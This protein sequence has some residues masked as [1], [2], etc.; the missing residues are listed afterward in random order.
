MDPLD[1]ALRATLQ[2]RLDELETAR[3]IQASPK[4]TIKPSPEQSS[5]E[6]TR[7]DPERLPIISLDS[8]LL[9]DQERVAKGSDLELRALLGQGGMG[10]VHSAFQYSLG[11]EV[12][13]KTLRED[14]DVLSAD[15]LLREA[16]L[17]GKLEHPGIVP[18]HALG[19]DENGAP[20]LVMKR[21]EG[22]QW[23]ALIQN[24]DHPGWARRSPDRVLA[25]LEI[26]M[27]ICQTVEFAHKRGVVHRDIKPENVMLGDFGEA[28]L[29]DWGIAVRLDPEGS[30]RSSG[31]AGT[32]AYM[33]PEMVSGER[34]DERSDVYL[35]GATLHEAL[36]GELRNRGETMEAVLVS[37]MRP[38]SCIYDTRVPAEIAAIMNRATSRDP[39]DRFP[40][41]M[42][43]REA[44]AEHL[45]H[46]GSVKLADQAFGRCAAL[47]TLMAESGDGKAPEDLQT[48]YQIASETR[49]AFT[50]ALREWPGNRDARTGLL[51]CLSLTVELE[52][53]QGH[54]ET[55]EALLSDIETPSTELL[56][57]LE[58]ARS[59]RDENEAERSRLRALER[60]LDTTV[61]A[62][63]R[64]ITLGIFAASGGMAS[65]FVVLSPNSEYLRPDVLLDIAIFF[66]VG[67]LVIA[68]LFRNTLMRPGFNRRSLTLFSVATAGLVISRGTAILEHI[69]LTE[70]L[71]QDLLVL[72]GVLATAAVTLLRWL[73]SMV[74]LQLA[75]LALS[76]AM[77]ERTPTIFAVVVGVLPAAIAF[78]LWRHR[79]DLERS[80]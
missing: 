64:S 10:R 14:A 3:T 66:F 77:P 7:P 57:H 25:H 49:F 32:P 42:A 46:R 15:A 61:S 73:W 56:S 19:V 29:V 41:A 62:K 72:T 1:P 36:T 28:Y 22:A 12:A 35:L 65:V 70:L 18:V 8:R 31:L 27:Q 54:V 52:L 74:V 63:L 9:P 6:W 43:L 30:P 16:V 11:R 50:E 34:V 67:C 45:H 23:G 59:E 75:A 17:T 39:N 33:A 78:S 71:T 60:D 79:V 44:I 40:S 55:A 48:T 38:E 53:R 24:A 21:I 76:L 80:K 68:L 5:D 47:S 37:A 2:L 58:R 26:L 69:T 4:A 13:V 20:I 51:E